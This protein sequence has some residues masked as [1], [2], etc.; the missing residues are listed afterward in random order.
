MV[1][2]RLDSENQIRPHQVGI[3][4]RFQVFATVEESTRYAVLCRVSYGILYSG[5]LSLRKRSYAGFRVDPSSFHYCVSEVGP[6]T[7]Y[8]TD[9]VD[10]FLTAVQV[11]ANESDDVPELSGHLAHGEEERGSL[12]RNLMFLR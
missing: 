9:A 1:Y 10:G 3:S 8:L 6:Y 12:W 2:I 5:Y 7:S 4:S 11:G